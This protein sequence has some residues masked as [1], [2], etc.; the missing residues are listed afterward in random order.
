MKDTK[1][2]VEGSQLRKGDYLQEDRVELER[3]AGVRSISSTSEKEENGGKEYE[4]LLERILDRNN[5]NGI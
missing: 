3:N 2:C 4:R 5:M 1:K